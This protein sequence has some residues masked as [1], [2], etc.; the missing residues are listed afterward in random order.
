MYGNAW[1]TPSTWWEYQCSDSQTEG[2]PNCEGTG[3]CTAVCY[4]PPFDGTITETDWSDYFY[5]DGTDAVFYGQSYSQQ[6][7]DACDG[8]Y[9][10][11]LLYWWDGPTASWYNLARFALE[12]STQGNGWG[13][14]TSDPAGIA[15]PPTCQA[16]FD[17]GT[18]VTL[19][20][21]PDPSSVFTGWSG[22]CS[23]TGACQI[24]INQVRSVTAN[25]VVKQF[26]LTVSGQG[27]GSGQVTSSPAG[28]ACPPVCQAGFDPGTAVTLTASPDAGS[29]FTGWSGDCS[30]TGAC[31]IT[32]NQARS[33]TANFALNTP[34]QA[35]FTVNCTALGCTFDGS[36]SAD[37]DGTIA[38]YTWDFGDG[39][40]GSGLTPS[41]SYATPGS[42]SVTLTVTDNAAAG[43]STS[44][45][46]SPITLAVRGY[47]QNGLEKVQLSWSGATGASFDVYRNSTRIATIPANVYT[48]NINKKGS[49]AYTY[50][51]CEAAIPIC[52]N[53]ATVSF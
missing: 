47:K 50:Q 18:T 27:S 45:T 41:H 3:A 34:P 26:D 28:I 13:G 17:T 48:D 38:A 44:M 19:T 36:G 30:G 53:T 1:P 39:S 42:Y 29:I 14:V 46:V 9:L 15:C 2:S 5:W 7:N 25:F 16:T 11:S 23:G 43:T 49:G 40:Q 22:D 51:V 35:S 31:Q 33:V 4:G 52:S 8:E 10:G 21:I 32:M 20:A 12:V 6:V 37:S 24:T